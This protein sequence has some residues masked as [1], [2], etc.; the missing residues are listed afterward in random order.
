MRIIFAVPYFEPG[1]VE[2]FLLGLG[3]F[4]KHQGHDISVLATERTG[5]WWPRLRQSDIQ[6]VCL[7]VEDS[8]SKHNHVRKI[9]RHLSECDVVLLNHCYYAQA[10]LSLLSDEI[11]AVPVLHNDVEDVYQLA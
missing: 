1:G 7:P 4:L 6:G 3:T 8:F 5:E 10:A 11:V 9:A 2:T